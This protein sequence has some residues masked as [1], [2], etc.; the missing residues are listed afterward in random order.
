MVQWD[1]LH[2]SFKPQWTHPGGEK[3]KKKRWDKLS[4]K[5]ARAHLTVW[6]VF[7]NMMNIYKMSLFIPSLPWT[8]LDLE[9]HN[10]LSNG[11][12]F[13]GIWVN[14]T[15]MVIYALL[16]FGENIERLRLWLI[17]NTCVYTHLINI[18]SQLTLEQ[19]WGGVRG[20]DLPWSCE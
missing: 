3:K 4:S 8:S 13:W 7:D 5:P 1:Y 11:R 20:L 18:W 10:L 17:F 6:C 12:L 9:S 19:W 15:K 14:W 2:L 16:F